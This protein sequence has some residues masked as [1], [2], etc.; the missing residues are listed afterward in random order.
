MKF[1]KRDLIYFRDKLFEVVCIAPAHRWLFF[2]R[3]TMGNDIP[4]FNDSDND[5]YL[6]AYD[7]DFFCVWDCAVIDSEATQTDA[8]RKSVSE[9]LRI[10]GVKLMDAIKA[11][12]VGGL[13]IEGHGD[14]A[15]STENINIR[16][17]IYTVLVELLELK[18][19]CK[20]II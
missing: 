8:T 4:Y 2:E 7:G 19:G 17:G 20:V 6:L 9:S 11:G 15:D 13:C 12:M 3:P 5:R 14:M 1:K 10:D 18:Y 16:Q